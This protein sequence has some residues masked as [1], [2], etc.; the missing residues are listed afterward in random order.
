MTWPF[1]GDAMV[2]ELTEVQAE[3]SPPSL[4][5]TKSP[6]QNPYVPWPHI[7]LLGFVIYV[8]FFVSFNIILTLNLTLK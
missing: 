3:G 1:T 4:N 7:F 8:R 2:T 6:I 5:P